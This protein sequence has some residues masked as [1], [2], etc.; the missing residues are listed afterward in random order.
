MEAI[1]RRRGVIS[2]KVTLRDLRVLTKEYLEKQIMNTLILVF[3]SVIGL[4]SSTQAESLEREDPIFEVKWRIDKDR[5]VLVKIR[6]ISKSDL[7]VYTTEDCSIKG[8]FTY[9]DKGVPPQETS[10]TTPWLGM[11][12]PSIFYPLEAANKDTFPEASVMHAHMEFDGDPS[13]ITK[14][15]CRIDYCFLSDIKN[16]ETFKQF[17]KILRT[18]KGTAMKSEVAH[19]EKS[20]KASS[21]AHGP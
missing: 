16:V 12:V 3:V 1:S 5:I 2:I 17:G 14:I 10:A 9:L 13:K 7:L 8:V 4:I 6:N 20:E 18:W 19:K 15:S 21:S 11:Y